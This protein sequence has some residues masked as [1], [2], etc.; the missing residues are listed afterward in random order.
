MNIEINKQY[1]RNLI[2]KRD[3]NLN[4]NTKD[5]MKK[6]KKKRK[7]NINNKKRNKNK[8][9]NNM[10]NQLVIASYIYLKANSNLIKRLKFK[11]KVYS[12]I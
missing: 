12:Q 5:N 6:N 1:L 4:K 2:W 11:K 9:G 7:K 8:K 3:F 10:K